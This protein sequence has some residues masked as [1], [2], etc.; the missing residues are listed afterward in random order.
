MLPIFQLGVG[1]RVGDGRQWMSWVH[2]D[3]HV[4]MTEYLLHATHLDGAFNATAPN[5]VTN[6]EFTECLARVLHR[7][8][9]FPVPG[10]ALQ[11]VLGE[12]AELLLGGQRVL[13]ARMLKEPFRFSYPSLEEALREALNLIAKTPGGAAS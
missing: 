13:P 10:R 6:R 4:A 11:L 9:F 2:L 8:A 5:P 7:P 12:M 1:G 3:D